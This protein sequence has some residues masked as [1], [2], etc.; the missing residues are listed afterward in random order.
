MV[1][2]CVRCGK[3]FESKRKTAICDDCKIQICVVCGKQ[4]ELQ[5]PYTQ[6][7]CSSR[8]RGEYRKLSGISK[9]VA[10]KSKQT[11]VKS[12]GTTSNV[13]KIKKICKYC[14]KE[15]ETTSNR[16]IYCYD[17]HYGPCPVCGKLVEIHDMAKGP[18]AC[19]TECRQ[20]LIERTN[21]EK[22]GTA[23]VFQ[24]D[25]VKEKIKETNVR[26]YGVDHYSKTDEYRMKFTDT[27]LSRYGTVHPMMNKE[28]QEKKVKTTERLYGGNSPTCNPV[29]AEKSKASLLDRYGGSGLSSPILK[30]KIQTTNI[31][32]Y[33]FV[34]PSKS[35]IVQQ[36]IKETLQRKYGGS[37][38]STVEG[39]SRCISDESKVEE[40]LKFKQSPSKYIQSNYDE[41]P[42]VSRLCRDLGVTDT[43]IYDALI[44]DNCRQL[45]E[46][47]SSN[48][49]NEIITY[50][51][52]LSTDIEII[53][54]SKKVITPLELD[55]YLPEYKFAI[56][57]NPTI[58]HN[59]SFKDPWG[60]NPK[61]YMYHK[62]KSDMCEEKGIQL[63][64]IFGY[65]WT[66][67]KEIIKSMIANDLGF[68][69]NK[70]Y[71]RNTQVVGISSEECKE[72]LNKNHRQGNTF[73]SIRLGLK[74]K[75]T[76]E[77]VSVMTFNKIR[78]TIGKNS[79]FDGYELSRFCSKLNT[80]VIGGASKLF[81]CFLKMYPNTNV[82][83]FSDKSHTSGKLYGVLGFHKVSEST[84]S[85]VW[86][87]MKD[88]SYY[89]RV[90]CQKKNLCKLFHDNSI[91]IENKTEKQIME[92]HGY[93]QVFDSGV[94]RWEYVHNNHNL[95]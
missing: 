37:Y 85:Y 72:F 95:V 68:T 10:E 86:V 42:L 25:D 24:N 88:D 79:R 21:L 34:T 4:F 2:T 26:K 58:T 11:K 69:S 18:S 56:E 93:A 75:K 87:N 55:I 7:T 28:L 16:R 33:G 12:Y 71:A 15:F 43:P 76:N 67:K 83:S 19:S 48:M 39:M 9:Q 84:P 81:E 47:K 22:Y 73:A 54:N 38:Q 66:Y 91:D 94:I 51:K 57:C 35:E 80:L 78:S 77:L 23:C 27:S 89:T 41:K 46:R 20:Q 8:C 44:L 1:Y 59:S 65:E 53:H 50:L 36:H 62:Q 64:H 3:H 17:K 92:E 40:Y 31:E 82:V 30:E 60:Q 5:W 90:T 13:K 29:V 6:K 63:F 45:V 61:Q 49:E 70:L 52:L 14:G 32:K 74:D